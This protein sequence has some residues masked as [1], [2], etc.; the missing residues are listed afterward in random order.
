MTDKEDPKQEEDHKADPLAKA[1]MWRTTEPGDEPEPLPTEHEIPAAA[2][3]AEAPPEQGPEQSEFTSLF[4]ASASSLPT[5]AEIPAAQPPA[6]EAPAEPSPAPDAGEFTSLFEVNASSLPADAAIPAEEQPTVAIPSEP[7]PEQSQGEF[8]SL[9]EV[10]AASL[11]TDAE[12]PAA[13]PSPEPPASAPDSIPTRTMQ[14]PPAAETPPRDA[15]E[16][17]EFTRMFRS[18]DVEKEPLATGPQPSPPPSEFTRM[19]QAGGST[20][21]AEPPP[22]E[23]PEPLPDTQEPGDFTRF[24][25][26]P[27]GSGS[28]AERDLSEATPEV[29][30]K[31]T[32]PEP[33]EYT[34]LFQTP[35]PQTRA[36][37]GSDATGVFE[38]RTEPQPSPPNEDDQGPSE[39]TQVIQASPSPEPKSA[40]SDEEKKEPA[41]APEGRSRRLLVVLVVSSRW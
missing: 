37:S 15:S 3:P 29:E 24:F 30:P 18:P 33:G 5:D 27:L 2:P 28:L 17:G 16:P 20:P 34:R 23:Q 1:G 36:E 9:F 21:P 25:H 38:Q 32:K 4:E 31:E 35:P 6:E 11:P 14:T 13:Q 40:S 12:I 22:P 7:P 26:S 10:S 19:F 8:T 39:F 41:P